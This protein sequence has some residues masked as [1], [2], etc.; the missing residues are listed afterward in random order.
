MNNAKIPR[1]F[2]EVKS[3]NYY[4]RV[5]DI[6]QKNVRQ[7]QLDVEFLLKN[8]TPKGTINWLAIGIILFCIAEILVPLYFLIKYLT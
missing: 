4:G 8:C 7:I 6:N 2:D 1:S 3:R 5:F